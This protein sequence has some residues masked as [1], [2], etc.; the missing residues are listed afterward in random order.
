MLEEIA[1]LLPADFEPAY[2]A[3]TIRTKALLPLP[4]V[5]LIAAVGVPG[6]AGTSGS[7]VDRLT[8]TLGI[9]FALIGVA[10]G[11]DPRQE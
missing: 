2:H 4:V 11:G 9:A 5:T 8:L 10:T 3:P 6:F 7:G 1:V